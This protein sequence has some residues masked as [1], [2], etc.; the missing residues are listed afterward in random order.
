MPGVWVCACSTNTLPIEL[1]PNLHFAFFMRVQF[2][3]L[4]QLHACVKSHRMHWSMPLCNF[5]S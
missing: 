2:F 5:L 1:Y 3:K 4:A